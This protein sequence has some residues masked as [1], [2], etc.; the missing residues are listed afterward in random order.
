MVRRSGDMPKQ[1][2]VKADGTQVY[3]LLSPEDVISHKILEL[4]MVHQPTLQS[5]KNLQSAYGEFLERMAAPWIMFV[6]SSVSVSRS[7]LDR[8]GYF[9]ERFK[10][11]WLEDWELG[12]RMHQAGATF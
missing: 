6:S 7:L 10:G 3:R 12:Y 1:L 9:D 4:G 5:F 11:A 2:L 8:A